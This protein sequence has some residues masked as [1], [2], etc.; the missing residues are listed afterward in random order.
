MAGLLNEIDAAVERHEMGYRE[1]DLLH[2]SLAQATHNPMLDKIAINIDRMSEPYKRLSLDRPFHPAET[3]REW[4]AIV[5]AIENRDPGG[6]LAGHVQPLPGKHGDL[7]RIQI[8]H[9]W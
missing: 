1:D 9:D 5:Q 7:S 4:H 8:R 3:C 2:F 6:D